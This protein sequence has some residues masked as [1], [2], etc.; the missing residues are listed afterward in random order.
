MGET[1]TV[2]C[3]DETVITKPKRGVFRGRRTQGH[4]QWVLGF[5]ELDLAT[6]TGTG[7]AVLIATPN[8]TRATLEAAIRNMFCPAL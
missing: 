6:R 2:V 3:I 7:R 5:Y 1:G 4:E 8:R